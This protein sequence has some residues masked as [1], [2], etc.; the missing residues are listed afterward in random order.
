MREKLED[1][2]IVLLDHIV[3]L[4]KYRD[5][6]VGGLDGAE[7]VEDFR[8]QLKRVAFVHVLKNQNLIG[9]ESLEE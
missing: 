5:S 3:Q 1:C 2:L 4:V 6:C 8:P 9:S 7:R